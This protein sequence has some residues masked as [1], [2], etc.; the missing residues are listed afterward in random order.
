VVSDH[1]LSCAQRI[2]QELAKRDGLYADL[3]R[4]LNNPDVTDNDMDAVYQELEPLGLDV[5]PVLV[6]ELS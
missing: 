1:K 3:W 2:E 4:R 5:R 6:V